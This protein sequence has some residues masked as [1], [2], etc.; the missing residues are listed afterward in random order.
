M[1]VWVFIRPSSVQPVLQSSTLS[2][3]LVWVS[4]LPLSSSALRIFDCSFSFFLRTFCPSLRL[5]L[6]GNTRR[7]CSAGVDFL[8]PMMKRVLVARHHTNNGIAISGSGCLGHYRRGQVQ[9]SARTCVLLGRGTQPWL[10][11]RSASFCSRRSKR[12]HRR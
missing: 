12:Q 4:V 6:S 2:V 10:T 3:P 9:N 8:R 1:K 5:V 7:M 11:L